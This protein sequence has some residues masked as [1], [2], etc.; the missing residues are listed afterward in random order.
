MINFSRLLDEGLLDLAGIVIVRITLMI[1]D[2][3]LE[4][5]NLL[6]RWFEFNE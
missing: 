3:I 2:G 6:Y 4:G 1:L 5:I